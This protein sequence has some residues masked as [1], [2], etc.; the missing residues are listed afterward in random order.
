MDMEMGY[1]LKDMMSAQTVATEQRKEQIIDQYPNPSGVG[2]PGYDIEAA[3]SNQTLNPYYNATANQSS[4]ASQ[5]FPPGSEARPSPIG[6]DMSEMGAQ[7][8]MP[9]PGSTAPPNAVSVPQL[10]QRPRRR[11]DLASPLSM[12][13][14]NGML[15]MGA[16]L[17]VAAFLIFYF[18]AP[19]QTTK[20]ISGASK[21]VTST[22]PSFANL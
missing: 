12:S 1:S 14:K 4:W 10:G 8:P 19:T 2:G 22:I 21:R 7:Q 16:G 13:D 3:T 15:V 9:P 20:T 17:V 11:Y 18:F 5:G 6:V